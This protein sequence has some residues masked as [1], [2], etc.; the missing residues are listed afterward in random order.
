MTS[1]RKAHTFKGDYSF[2]YPLTSYSRTRFMNIFPCEEFQR[3]SFL[4]ISR[5]YSPYLMVERTDMQKGRIRAPQKFL[6]ILC[7]VIVSKHPQCAAGRQFRTQAGESG[8]RGSGSRGLASLPLPLWLPDPPSPASSGRGETECGPCKRATVAG[9]VPDVPDLQGP[10]PEVAGAERPG[11][12]TKAW[13]VCCALPRGGAWAHA[14]AHTRAHSS[15]RLRPRGLRSGP[16]HPRLESGRPQHLPEDYILEGLPGK[17]TFNL[18]VVWVSQNFWSV[19]GTLQTHR[20][21]Y[22][23]RHLAF[24][25]DYLRSFNIVVDF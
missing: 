6:L 24:K 20:S 13:A 25:R 16:D 18:E 22:K 2:L 9:S 11:H 15:P 5:D 1:P 21:F 23:V 4:W 14:R 3:R 12:G 17:P 8:V 10:R 19:L 7:Y